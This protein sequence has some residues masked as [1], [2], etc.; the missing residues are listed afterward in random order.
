MSLSVTTNVNHQVKAGQIIFVQGMPCKS[1]NFLMEGEIEILATSE[2]DLTG[3]EE[4]EIID[5]SRRVC[6]L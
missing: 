6:T 5:D 4:R 2:K 1:I 3:M